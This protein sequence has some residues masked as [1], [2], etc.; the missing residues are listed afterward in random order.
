MLYGGSDKTRAAVQQQQKRMWARQD[1][2]FRQMPY[3]RVFSPW[4][5]I[6]KFDEDAEYIK[7]WIPELSDVSPRDISQWNATHSEY[8]KIKYPKPIVDYDDQKVKMLAMY[9]RALH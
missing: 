7:R 6:D 3:F 4:V 1:S 5:Q 2:Q 9:G 8:P